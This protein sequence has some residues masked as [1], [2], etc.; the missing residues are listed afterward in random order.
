MSGF[1]IR[2]ANSDDI[3]ALYIVAEKMKASNEPNYFERCIQEYEAGKREIFLA[4]SASEILGYVQL[5]WSPIYNLFRRLEIP[6]IQDLSVIPTAR[7]QGIGAALVEFCEEEAKKKGKEEIGIGF[8]L[9]SSFGAAQRL[10]IKKGYIPD[11]L[12]LCYNDQ[13]IEIGSFKPVDDFLT[14]KLVKTIK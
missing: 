13:T 14:L 11:G 3:P 5:I 12:G 1:K 8:G 2:K 7:N 6:E 9:H 4:V 10:Y